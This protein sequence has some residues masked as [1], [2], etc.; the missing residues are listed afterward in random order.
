M[1]R[2]AIH[3]PWQHGLAKT[4]STANRTR[5]DA[6]EKSYKK[7]GG[8]WEERSPTAD[9][10]E[11]NP[12]RSAFRESHADRKERLRKSLPKKRIDERPSRGTVPNRGTTNPKYKSGFWQCCWGCG[13]IHDKLFC[14][15]VKHPDW[16]WQNV[17]WN[18]SAKGIA[19]AEK[20][21][22][23]LPANETLDGHY[24]EIPN[25]E[26]LRSGKSDHKQSRESNTP[27]RRERSLHHL[28]RTVTDNKVKFYHVIIVTTSVV[29]L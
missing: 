6:R 4:S 21:E 3:L 15:L 1:I 2:R 14:A 28:D 25:F 24:V 18:E 13:R 10:R 8:D 9:S 19:W 22:T 12:K 23:S 27:H 11:E 20:G 16:N 5:K 29:C 7:R 26:G 17:P